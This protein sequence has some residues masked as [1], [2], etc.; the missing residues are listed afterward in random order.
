MEEDFE[1]VIPVKLG[2]A[3]KQDHRGVG[4]AYILRTQMVEA[5]GSWDEDQL[6]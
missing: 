5:G 2:K 6:G 1:H 3:P 4:R